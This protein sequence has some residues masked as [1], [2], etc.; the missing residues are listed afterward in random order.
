MIT[1]FYVNN[2][3]SL[4]AFEM[5][6][7]SMNV[8]CG[9]NGTG[10]SSM[11]DA[12]QFVCALAAGNCFLGGLSNTRGRMVSQLEFTNWMQSKT[13][14]FEIDILSDDHN[15]RYVIHLEQIGSLEPRIIKETVICDGRE[16]YTRDME[17]VHFDNGRSGFPL[18]W[19]QAALASIQPVPERCEIELLQKALANLLVLRPSVYDIEFESKAEARFLN[20]NLSNFTSWHRHLAQNQEYTDLLRDSLKCVWP[21]LKF[22]ILDDA[23][24]SVKALKLRFEDTDIYFNQLSDGEKMLVVLYAIYAALILGKINTVM[25]DEPDNFISLQE[26]QPWLLSMS[27]LTD[28]EHQVLLISHNA[29]IIDNSPSS[30]YIFL[31]DNHNAPTRVIN[32]SE[33][34]EG[35]TVA[36]ALARGWIGSGDRKTA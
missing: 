22:L 8:F 31:R 18:D 4:V 9:A 29:E 35:L 2:Y 21:N 17:G 25:I 32:A 20:I 10:K 15:F 7:D 1:R 19:R 23:G 14:E 26:L 34:P 36:E 6:F 16:I 24:M 27:E 28:S 5:K 12:I 11:F 3:R 33:T 13:Q 30:G